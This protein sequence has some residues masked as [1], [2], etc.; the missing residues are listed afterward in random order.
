[1]TYKKLTYNGTKCN[2]YLYFSFDSNYFDTDMVTSKLE[3]KP[4]SLIIK[5]DPIP[6]FTSWKYKIDVGNEIDLE[7]PLEKLIDLFEKKTEEINGL[8][9]KLGLTTR[10]QFVID[11]DINP[12]VSTPYFGLNKRAIDFL[13][14]TGTEVDFDIYK[15]DTI[16]VFNG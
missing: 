15:V 12:N 4:T 10:L 8:K 14:K 7:T 3:I 13:N 6:K 9:N 2:N 1:M 5:N 11:I 16:G